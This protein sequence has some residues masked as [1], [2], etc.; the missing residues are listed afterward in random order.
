MKSFSVQRIVSN[1]FMYL[2]QIFPQDIVQESS[3]FQIITNDQNNTDK[4]LQNQKEILDNQKQILEKLKKNSRQVADLT[5]LI[6]ESF[7]R[8]A[9]GNQPVVKL[10]EANYVESESFMIKPIS[11]ANE[12]NELEINLSDCR[13]KQKLHFQYALLCNKS[14]GSG[15]SY[16]YK[17]LDI[18]FTRDFLCKCSWSGGSKGQLV[19]VAFKA[20]KNVL[21]FFFSL[22]NSWDSTYTHETNEKFFKTV[23]KNSGKRLEIKNLRTSTKRTRKDSQKCKI[24][25]RAKTAEEKE[26]V[27]DSF[28]SAVILEKEDL[29]EESLC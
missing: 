29:E 2:F 4:I 18:M 19:K 17:L 6:D 13:Q 21:N 20:Y 23:L 3:V 11:D 9:E 15:I 22:I 27:E 1:Q 25:K 10:A 28:S 24:T 16:A 5:V 12:L 7:K 8:L 26:N 14:D